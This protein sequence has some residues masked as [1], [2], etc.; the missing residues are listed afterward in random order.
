MAARCE[1]VAVGL[2]LWLSWS[3]LIPQV[4]T[5]S[6]GEL[7]GILTKISPGLVTGVV[8]VE[9]EVARGIATGG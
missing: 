9:A 7:A 8:F 4:Q 1:I 3:W 5:R 2:A 6:T